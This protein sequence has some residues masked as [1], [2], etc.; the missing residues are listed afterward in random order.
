MFFRGLIYESS[1]NAGKTIIIVLLHFQCIT[2]HTVVY[3]YPPVISGVDGN[4]NNVEGK[5]L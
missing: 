2:P 4:Y 1:V 3:G 5:L